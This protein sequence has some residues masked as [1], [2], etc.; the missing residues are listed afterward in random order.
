[1][2][3]KRALGMQ[4]RIWPTTRIKVTRGKRSDL[5][6]VQGN[7]TAKIPEVYNKK[8]PSPADERPCFLQEK[9][10]A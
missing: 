6:L 9:M 7:H 3:L 4:T 10:Y 2:A 8:I 5:R 1:M